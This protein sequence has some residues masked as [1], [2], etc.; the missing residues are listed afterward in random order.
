MFTVVKN[1]QRRTVPGDMDKARKTAI[2]EKLDTIIKMVVGDNNIVTCK[3]PKIPWVFWDSCLTCTAG[4]QD[5]LLI[6][7][8]DVDRHTITSDKVSRIFSIFKFQTKNTTNNNHQTSVLWN[9]DVQPFKH[10]KPTR[11]TLK[12]VLFL[13]NDDLVVPDVM[14]NYPTKWFLVGL[15]YLTQYYPLEDR[16]LEHMRT[17][18]H[19]SNLSIYKRL[20][21]DSQDRRFPLTRREI[22][23]YMRF[24]YLES[25]NMNNNDAEEEKKIAISMSLPHE[26]NT[27]ELY[28]EISTHCKTRCT[29]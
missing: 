19:Y 9:E 24:R 11:H 6:L 3:T 28:L 27:S 15:L 8:K 14:L 17:Y 26:M 13:M 1:T 4:F 5:P 7:N 21:K 2:V 12:L 10:P 18:L 23:A 25:V 22:D 20:R 29:F 16:S